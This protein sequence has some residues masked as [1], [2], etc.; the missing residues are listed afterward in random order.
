MAY[1]LDSA[2]KPIPTFIPTGSTILSTSPYRVEYL[3]PGENIKTSSPIGVDAPNIQEQFNNAVKEFETGGTAAG[4][5]GKDTSGIITKQSEV[6]RGPIIGANGSV[7]FTGKKEEPKQFFAPN[8]T[9][10]LTEGLGDMSAQERVSAQ[11]QERRQTNTLEDAMT[12]DTPDGQQRVSMVEG[13]QEVNG[14][15]QQDPQYQAR[16][17]AQIAAQAQST[18]VTPDPRTGQYA[19]KSGETEDQRIQRLKKLGLYD[20]VKELSDIKDRALSIQN[21]I[22]NL[23]ADTPQAQQAYDGLSQKFG[24]PPATDMQSSFFTDPIGTIKGITQQIFQTMGMGEAN[25]LITQI[26]DELEDLEND[27][28]QEIR[29]INDNPWLTEGVRVRQIQKAEQRWGDQ[30]DNRVNKLRLLESVRDDARQQAQFALGTAISIYDTERRFQQDQVQMYYDQAQREFDNSIKLAQFQMDKEAAS[31]PDK[32]TSDMQEY[33]FAVENGQFSGSFIDWKSTVAASTRAPS[34]GGSGLVGPGE[35]LY[36]GLSSPT[37][38]AVRSMVGKFGSEPLVQNFA[39]I[40]E[41]YNFSQSIS[42]K[43]QNP[44]D[45]Q[46]LI[47][48]LAKAL[49]PGSVV[50]EGEYATAQKYAQS[51][52]SAY[53][54][55]V[56]QAIAGTGFLSEQARNN[57]KNVIKTKYDSAQTSY[58]NLQSQY[59]SRI[60]NLTGRGDGTNFLIDYTTPQGEAFMGPVQ[61][62]PEA[63]FDEVVTTDS[64]GGFFSNFLSGL[65]FR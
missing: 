19:L 52:I 65:L 15:F 41:G 54:K 23:P 32:G 38:T 17:Q 29:D 33:L 59:T 25:N 55:G 31:R 47:Y 51:W 10:G 60:N 53:G 28:D 34:S 61:P 12:A 35:Q 45:D 39:T 30:I 8:A 16:Q 20:P 62:T 21:Q 64:G 44:A 3:R 14:Q 46:A 57:I 36:S 48:A 63:D 27:R 58:N 6:D 56:T 2:G 50:R 18:P 4:T 9:G 42:T 40:Q 24:L 49:D 22:Q 43:T 5:T 26:S 37:A 11:K 1:N 13:G 7:F